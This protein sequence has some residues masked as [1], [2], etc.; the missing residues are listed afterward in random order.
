ML[1][2]DH[3]CMSK[4]KQFDKCAL[5]TVMDFFYYYLIYSDLICGTDIQTWYTC[6]H[7][8][9]LNLN[10]INY[11]STDKLWLIEIWCSFLHCL[12]I[13]RNRVIIL[14]VYDVKA[15]RNLN[16]CLHHVVTSWFNMIPPNSLKYEHI[17]INTE[18]ENVLISIFE[19]A[20]TN[21]NKLKFPP[22]SVKF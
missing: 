2:Q 8:L 21:F 3:S 9:S 16:A 14:S 1:G 10:L 13:Q 5:S 12:H 17:T 22:C 11:V 15:N 19:L 18:S 20:I 7:V 6:V 4:R